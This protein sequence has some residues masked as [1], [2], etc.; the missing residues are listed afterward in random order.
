ML[1]DRAAQ[2]ALVGRAAR[3]WARVFGVRARELDGLRVC[4]GLPGWAYPRGGV[5]WG[6]TYVCGPQPWAVSAPRLRHE[7]VH[8][9]QWRRYGLAFALLYLRAGR[10]PRTNRFEV[11][12]GLADGGYGG[13]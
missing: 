11:E 12:A 10:D 1:L 2:A 5:T 9:R 7:S 3:A 4:A 6:D 8:V 13:G